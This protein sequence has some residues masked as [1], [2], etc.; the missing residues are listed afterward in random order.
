MFTKN[1]LI[2]MVVVVITGCSHN[3]PKDAFKLTPTSLEDKEMQTRSFDTLNQANLLSASGSV[4]Q[5]LGYTLEESDTTIGVLS[6]SKDIDATDAGQVVGAVILAI[7][8]GS[9]TPVDDHQKIRVCLV[10]NESL[11]N[12]NASLARITIQRIVWNTEGRISKVQVIK[13]PELYNAFFN[14]LSKAVFLE[15]NNI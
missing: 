6:A 12:E 8:T 5:D 14:K 2:M 4:L 13:D 7:F 11:T 15:E 3:P 1:V 9:M 10:I